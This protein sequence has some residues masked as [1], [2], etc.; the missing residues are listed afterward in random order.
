MEI[1][2]V[3]SVVLHCYNVLLM[4]IR[5][6]RRM[7]TCACARD[8]KFVGIQIPKHIKAGTGAH[9]TRHRNRT[10]GYRVLQAGYPCGA[11]PEPAQSPPKAR[12][13]TALLPDTRKSTEFGGKSRVPQPAKGARP[14]AAISLPRRSV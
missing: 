5:A 1:S 10:N 4:Y 7:I 8:K 12:D 3:N 11:S 2:N 6:S 13:P 14:E 9:A